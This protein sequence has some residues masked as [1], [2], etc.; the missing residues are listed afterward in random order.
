M[1]KNI[2]NDNIPKISDFLDIYPPICQNDKE[3]NNDT[4]KY[5]VYFNKLILKRISIKRNTFNRKQSS[6]KNINLENSSFLIDKAIEQQNNNMARTHDI[7][8]SIK[9]FLYHSNLIE[10]LNNF[11][12]NGDISN[13][14]SM[15]DFQENIKIIITKL[16]ENVILEKIPA[17]KFILKSNEIG[18]DCY[19]LISGK[20]SILKPVEYQN[21]IIN[22]NDY[23]KYLRNLYD[24]NEYDL[25]K[26]VLSTNN[27]YYLKIYSLDKILNDIDEVKKFIKSYCITKLNLKIKNNL[28]NYKDIHKI[29]NELKEFNFSFLDFNI[30]ENE[31]EETI[32][33]I[34]SNQ[35]DDTITKESK[36]K[37]YILEIFGPSQ[38]DIKIMLPYDYLLSDVLKESHNTNN[39]AV[40]Y[41]YEVF[42]YLYPGT[43]FGETSTSLENVSNNRRNEIIRTEE[44]CNIISLKQNLYSTILYEST[45]LIKD[46]DTS[47]L[48]KNYFFCEIPMNLFNKLYFP[49]FKLVTKNKNDLIFKQNSEFETICFLKEG[50]I[51]FETYL[52]AIEIFDIIK[53]FINYLMNRKKY[54]NISNEQIDNLKKNYLNDEDLIY[55]RNNGILYKEKIEE[56][57][58]YEIYSSNNYETIG[59]LEFCSLLKKYITSS[60]VVS[61]RAKF[62]EINKNNLKIILKR[63]KDIHE[64]YYKLIKNKILIQ[65]K[66]LYSL[67]L[68]YLSK[69][70]YKIK[71]NFY[72]LKNSIENINHFSYNKENIYSYDYLNSTKTLANEF[73]NN[74]ND[75]ISENINEIKDSPSENQSNTQNTH[76]VHYMK[77]EQPIKTNKFSKY[78][79]HCDY[80]FIGNNNWSPVGLRSIKF[81]DNFFKNRKLSLKKRSIVKKKNNFSMNH[82]ENN[83]DYNKIIKTLIRNETEGGDPDKMHL[84]S[85]NID[86][87]INKKINIG[88][89][90]IFTLEQLRKKVKQELNESIV[91][92]S[93]GKNENNSKI[94]H[95]VYLQNK[96][97]NYKFNYPFRMKSKLKTIK[98]RKIFLNNKRLNNLSE[99]KKDPEQLVHC[100][101]KII[102]QPKTKENSTSYNS[103]LFKSFSNRTYRKVFLN[104][105]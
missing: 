59:I 54:F 32:N 51:K 8:E 104:K 3:N 26:K 19:F 94:I 39:S 40:L 20:M 24:N 28:I 17:N 37:K 47:Y 38:D 48:R 80:D 15:N 73:T 45:K 6:K 5:L 62:F 29:D 69:I 100:I 53:Y 67:K 101:R 50:E 42:H 84:K 74:K 21:I 88:N 68:N 96:E 103:N 46:S 65:I 49:M 4:K 99:I 87:L 23:F 66:R 57:T 31:I 14:Q 9:S 82:S 81:N 63:E 93:V 90:H 60:Y 89:N 34:S 33:N 2:Q 52:S 16:A 92:L 78:F 75:I 61:N 71:Q 58:K 30:D 44:D 70:K 77:I 91:N 18:N 85:E 22:Y 27:K 105:K 11:Y 102:S 36:I 7:K 79:G 43:F 95:K 86:S 64:D 83:I 97:Y 98:L 55:G 41:K 72:N 35:N 25:L 76:P 56:I 10:Q 12:T 13:N 1:E